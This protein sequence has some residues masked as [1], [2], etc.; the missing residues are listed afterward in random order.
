M[1]KYPNYDNYDAIEVPFTECIP[2]DYEGVMGVPITFFD[3]YNP[4]QF[5]VLGITDRNNE[6]GLTIKTYTSEDGPNYSDCNRRGAIRVADGSLKSTYARLL[7][8]F[9]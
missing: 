9:K 5:E 7:I 4:E 8:R 6:W 1:I 2:S 3:K